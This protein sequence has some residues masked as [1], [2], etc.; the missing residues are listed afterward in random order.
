MDN[1]ASAVMGK[2]YGV[3]GKQV[4]R[5]RGRKE[6]GVF[7]SSY[8]CQNR[9]K[10]DKN[11]RQGAVRGGGGKTL[12]YQDVGDG[13]NFPVANPNTR[14]GSVTRLLCLIQRLLKTVLG[15]FPVCKLRDVKQHICPVPSS[16]IALDACLKPP[17]LLGSRKVNLVDS[18]VAKTFC[19]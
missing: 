1:R 12:Y 5:H 8:R 4:Q 16:V 10:T 2:H 11:G 15:G 14:L 18:K 17:F 13:S 19:V 7:E 3:W 9:K 6:L